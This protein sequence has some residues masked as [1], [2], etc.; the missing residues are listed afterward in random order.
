MYI[1]AMKKMDSTPNEV[2]F[3]DDNPTYIEGAEVLGIKGIL[4]KNYKNLEERLRE[5]HV[6]F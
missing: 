1:R 3:I 4:F 6:R 2:I 5:Y